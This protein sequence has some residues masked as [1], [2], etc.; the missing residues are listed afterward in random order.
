MAQKFRLSLTQPQINYLYQLIA[1]DTRTET[2]S[3]RKATLN[4]LTVYRTKLQVGTVSAAFNSTPKKSLIEQLGE[5]ITPE[6]RRYLAYQKYSSNPELC[7]E[8]E[9]ALAETYIFEHTE[10]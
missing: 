10:E 5:G 4:Y 6:E 1:A 8:E 7:T 3:L 2:E 9:I